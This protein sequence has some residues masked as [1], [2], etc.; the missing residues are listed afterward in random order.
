[1]L[2]SLPPSSLKVGETYECVRCNF[3]SA[4]NNIDIDNKSYL[5]LAKSF[6]KLVNKCGRDSL[7]IKKQEFNLTRNSGS[8]KDFTG[9][10]N[11]HY[12]VTLGL[13]SQSSI[14]KNMIRY[15]TDNDTTSNTVWVQ[16]AQILV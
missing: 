9:L 4:N 2:L 15:K 13:F 16:I 11:D 10:E 6:S 3:K 5:I 14:D 1:M 12:Y 7:A 8:L